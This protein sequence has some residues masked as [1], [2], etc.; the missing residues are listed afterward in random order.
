MQQS[1]DALT[2]AAGNQ[3]RQDLGGLCRAWLAIP[4]LSLVAAAVSFFIKENWRLWIISETALPLGMVLL[5]GLI[6]ALI[7][8]HKS[9]NWTAW[10]RRNSKPLAAALV[11]C[12]ALHVHDEQTEK[13]LLDEL[14][15]QSSAIQLLDSNQYRIPLFSHNQHADHSILPGVPDKRP[16]LFPILLSFGHRLFG[17]SPQNGFWLNALLGGLVFFSIAKIAAYFLPA[18]GWLAAM[19]L[20]AT[21]PVVSQ[22]IHSQHMEMLYLALI[23]GLLWQSLRIC[24]RDRNDELP[25]AYL[26]AAL[27]GMTRYEGLLFLIVPFAIHAFMMLRHPD[28][29]VIPT[30]I[31]TWLVPMA[32][33]YLFNLVHHVFANPGFW[34]LED[35]GNDNPFGIGYLAQN[36]RSCFDYLFAIDRGMSNSALMSILGLA[37]CLT[38]APIALF[39]TVKAL[40]TPQHIQPI[41]FVLLI[42]GTVCG[43]FLLLIF[44]Y[45]WGQVNTH[46]T[47][48][49]MLFPYLFMLLCLLYAGQSQPRLLTGISLLL[50]AIVFSHAVVTKDAV[51]PVTLLILIAAIAA[52]PMVTIRIPSLTRYL[53][54]FIGLYLISETLPAIH[55]KRYEFEA[56][57][58]WRAATFDQWIQEFAG[59]NILFISESPFYAIKRR[60]ATHSIAHL[61]DEPEIILSF[62]QQRLI[63]DAFV[64]QA[65]LLQPDGNYEILDKCDR[66]TYEVIYWQR[67]NYLVGARMIRLTGFAGTDN[68]AQPP[69]IEL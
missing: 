52:F 31:A 3:P 7:R 4:I 61:T 11:I 29:R 69:D 42:F 35:K 12:V 47:A 65:F 51:F 9:T 17:F 37:A 43:L 54:L 39:H 21:L 20:F 28:R 26:M 60:E 22:N 64:L 41:R 62:L 44:S 63:S 25:I 30:G 10:L 8:V 15:L 48:R 40:R 58:M 14:V 55:E 27:I 45:H 57:P 6:Y 68:E 32:V 18:A 67:F 5:V 59:Q 66:F 19:L 49:F 38:T 53:P 46:I 23:A 36:V 56:D 34:Q 24:C 1:D 2:S 33:F 13:V 16:P 50:V